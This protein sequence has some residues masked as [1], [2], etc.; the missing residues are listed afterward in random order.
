MIADV[1]RVVQVPDQLDHSEWSAAEFLD[2]QLSDG[3]VLRAL[4]CQLG[5]G[6]WQ[7]T[8]SSI[9]G[10]RGDLICAGTEQSAISARL[11]ARSE[12][13]KCLED[14]HS[15]PARCFDASDPAT[16]VFHHSAKARATPP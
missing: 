2:V 4:V 9:E 7:W 3:L 8:I 14:S 5:V 15:S 6:E 12:L 1:I 13:A 16:E 11:I 10:D